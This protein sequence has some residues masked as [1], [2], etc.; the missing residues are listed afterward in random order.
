MEEKVKVK[1]RILENQLK[2]AEVF[3]LLSWQFLC[4]IV[5]FG[6]GL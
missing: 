6:N 1:M 4:S 5:Q 3:I 2:A